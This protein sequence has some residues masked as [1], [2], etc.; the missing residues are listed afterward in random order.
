MASSEEWIKFN[1]LGFETYIILDEFHPKR[2][3][4]VY[5]EGTILKLERKGKMFICYAPGRW[6]F[7]KI[8]NSKYIWELMITGE[9]ES[10]D[11]S[12]AY[13]DYVV[14]I[15]RDR[16][17]KKMLKPV[18]ESEDEDLSDASEDEGEA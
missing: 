16:K 10:K 17:N 8:R 18:E 12:F 4:P 13:K 9:V 11:K 7:K 14:K 5:G 6:K 3:H 2:K 1:D 15:K